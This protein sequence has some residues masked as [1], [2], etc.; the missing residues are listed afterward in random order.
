MTPDIHLLDIIDSQIAS[1]SGKNLF[2]GDGDLLS[3]TGRTKTLLA[4]RAKLRSLLSGAAFDS[5]IDHTVS[6]VLR[7]LYHGDQ[8]IDVN[9]EGREALRSL[10]VVMADELAADGPDVDHIARRHYRRL[11]DWL[12][13]TSPYMRR[14]NPS[15]R[16][17]IR[18]VVCAEYSPELQMGILGLDLHDLREPVLDIGCGE[19]AGLVEYL[20]GHGIDA[21]GLD[22]LCD[23][24]TRYLTTES[25]FDTGFRPGYWGTLISN[26][27]FSSHFLN[28]HL[29]SDGSHVGY[30]T[31]YMEILNSLQV[32]GRYHYAPGIPFIERFL[33]TDRFIV[34]RTLLTASHCR[35]IVG[36]IG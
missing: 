9:G 20:R 3:F 18:T 36:R 35:T 15:E 34:A 24:G 4:D 7:N 30:A 5:L 8:Y 16:R 6:A 17:T 11:A 32:G 26:L 2:H 29:R 33:P 12:D 10:Y 19:S 21:F 23:S 28:S 22:R 27:S 1:N 13:R 31:K 14:A 25:W